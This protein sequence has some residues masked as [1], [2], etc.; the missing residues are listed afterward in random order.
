MTHNRKSPSVPLRAFTLEELEKERS[1]R[2]EQELVMVNNR[3]LIIKL[4]DM[5]NDKYWDD[6]GYTGTIFTKT[7]DSINQ[8][9]KILND[10]DTDDVKKL[11]QIKSIAEKKV[12]ADSDVPTYSTLDTQAE[13]DK[14][15]LYWSFK[16][17]VGMRVGVVYPK[18][19]TMNVDEANDKLD[20]IQKKIDPGYET[21]KKILSTLKELV[22]DKTFWANKGR[23][24]NRAGGN[25]NDFTPKCIVEFREIVGDNRITQKEK[26]KAIQTVIQTHAKKDTHDVNDFMNKVSNMIETKSSEEIGNLNNQ[27]KEANQW[28]GQKKDSSKLLNELVG[29][30]NAEKWK[31]KGQGLTGKKIPD[32]IEKC[33]EITTLDIPADLRLEK[34][35]MLVHAKVKEH[36][37]RH[38]SVFRR[39]PD[40]EV[41]AL[42]KKIDDLSIE[43]HGYV[44]AK[45][46]RKYEKIQHAINDF[47]TESKTNRDSSEF[48]YKSFD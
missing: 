29:V 6:V 31:T 24:N 12:E 28:R 21:D 17:I 26:L 20:S 3:I 14:K 9:R 47:A 45:T 30:L 42:Y 25:D 38:K 7:P 46:P 44:D 1:N 41:A 16:R 8:Y 15:D 37:Q 13:I 5:V 40:P 36:K 11:K 19:K 43:W 23:K 18:Y 22:D 32:G 48:A 27:R 33:I 39:N 10:P 35:F 34:I 4:R 2:K